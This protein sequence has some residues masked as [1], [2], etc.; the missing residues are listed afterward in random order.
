MN[1]FPLSSQLVHHM[2]VSLYNILRWEYH[3]I[4]QRITTVF[5]TDS[6]EMWPPTSRPHLIPYVGPCYVG[7]SVVSKSVSSYLFPC[8]VS[9]LKLGVAAQEDE[10]KI[11]DL[12]DKPVRTSGHWGLN[13]INPILNPIVHLSSF[14][15]RFENLKIVVDVLWYFLYL[16]DYKQTMI[17]NNKRLPAISHNW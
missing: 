3:R 13:K 15:S 2:Y 4:W 9:V 11:P 6:S 12:T 17:N 10:H 16:F 5:I 8:F 14:I 1:P 7:L